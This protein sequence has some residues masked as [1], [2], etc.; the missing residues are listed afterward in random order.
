MNGLQMTVLRTWLDE[1]RNREGIKAEELILIVNDIDKNVVSI[2]ALNMFPV[3]PSLLA[4]V[5]QN[6]GNPHRQFRLHRTYLSR[7]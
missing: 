1:E 5:S 4:G 6:F 3:T 2:K 7:K